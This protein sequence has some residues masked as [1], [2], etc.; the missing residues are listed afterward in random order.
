MEQPRK[1]RSTDQKVGCMKL[2]LWGCI[3]ASNDKVTAFL[4]RPRPYSRH[5]ICI[6]PFKWHKILVTY[7]ISTSMINH[8]NKEQSSNYWLFFSVAIQSFLQRQIITVPPL[9]TL[10]KQGQHSGGFL[11]ISKEDTN[12]FTACTEV[13]VWSL[14]LPDV[15]KD[16]IYIIYKQ[17]W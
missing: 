3:I 8:C 14:R 13:S 17:W 6:H 1:R 9:L 4:P 7:L 15:I 2:I 10:D 11:C 16:S 12:H 5:L